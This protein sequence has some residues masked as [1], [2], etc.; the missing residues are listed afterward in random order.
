M[1]AD[2]AAMEA[3]VDDA[4]EA[5]GTPL[6]VDGDHRSWAWLD[7]GSNVQFQTSRSAAGSWA[8]VHR[9][10]DRLLLGLAPLRPADVDGLRALVVIPPMP[11][12]TQLV[13]DVV[14][15][16]TAPRRAPAHELTRSAVLAGRRAARLARLG[17]PSAD[18]A[19]QECAHHW[20]VLGDAQRANLALRHG[21]RDD[22]G[23]PRGRAASV[24]SLLADE[25]G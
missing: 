17:D 23:S 21:Q 11:D 2:F 20:R 14:D 18:A 16:P 6:P 15:D 22:R 4:R 9:A 10:A 7:R 5:P 1:E 24:G 8:R 12:P 3:A 19:W 25:L 13:V